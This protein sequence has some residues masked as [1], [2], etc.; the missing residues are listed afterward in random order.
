MTYF[1]GKIKLTEW[2]QTPI[3]EEWGWG[4]C[5]LRSKH[6]L[7]G[8]KNWTRR[9]LFVIKTSFI[10]DIEKL[11]KKI[12]SHLSRHCVRDEVEIPLISNND[13]KSPKHVIWL[14]DVPNLEV[15]NCG[16][17]LN[18]VSKVIEFHL[19]FSYIYDALL[20]VI[21]IGNMCICY[22]SHD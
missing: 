22:V 16:D 17:I 2:K 12:K 20:V 10:Q 13:W 19:W 15:F 1:I 5:V 9:Y 4:W 6:L 21:L 7:S 8:K 11:C 18:F 3:L 14:L